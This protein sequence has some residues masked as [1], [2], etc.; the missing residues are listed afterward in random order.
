VDGQID[1][2]VKKPRFQFFRKEAFA[3]D[4]G[5]GYVENLI[6]FGDDMLEGDRKIRVMT[7]EGFFY[8]FGL[9]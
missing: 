4:A 9:P 2:A 7:L 8:V 1:G 3:A 6:A 5:Q